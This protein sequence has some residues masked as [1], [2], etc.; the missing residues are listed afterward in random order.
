[1]SYIQRPTTYAQ[2]INYLNQNFY[3]VLDELV[4][5][6]PENKMLSK[7]PDFDN[8]LPQ[9]KQKIKQVTNQLFSLKDRIERSIEL[10]EENNTAIDEEITQLREANR[11]LA[12]KYKKLIETNSAAEGLNY[13]TTE[14]YYMKIV[15]LILLIGGIG[16]A[17]A[18]LYKA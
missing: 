15:N 11:L 7:Y 17:G 10:T 8:T 16:A 12:D 13:Q 6:Y 1:M 3:I 9:D 14:I 5:R 2:H 18:I 4:Q